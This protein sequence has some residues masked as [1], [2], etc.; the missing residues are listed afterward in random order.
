MFALDR[1]IF[2]IKMAVCN[3]LREMFNYMGLRRN[4]ICADYITI[5][6]A[7]RLRYGKR[8]FYSFSLFCHLEFLL[9]YH[10]DAAYRALMCTDSAP[11]AVLQVGL[12]MPV[13][14]FDDGHVRAE[15]PAYAAPDALTAVYLRPQ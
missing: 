8:Y 12:E 7:D 13:C 3:Q 9:A 10:G 5:R 14:R 11:L 1:D 6:L 15:Y 2:C 4:G